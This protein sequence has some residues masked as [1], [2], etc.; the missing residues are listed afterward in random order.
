MT[1]GGGCER[2]DFEEVRREIMDA[3]EAPRTSIGSRMPVSSSF[4]S[5]GSGE[6]GAAME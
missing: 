6:Y 4:A 3:F 5:I 2:D 1:N